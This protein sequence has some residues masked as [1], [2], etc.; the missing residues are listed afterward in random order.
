MVLR[1]AD[2]RVSFLLPGDIEKESEFDLADEIGSGLAS[3]V[4]KLAHHGS[5]TS[6]S[7]LFLDA[8]KPRLAVISLAAF[9]SYGFPHREVIDRLQRRGI[10]WL[11]TARSGGIMI[12]PSPEGL[13][14]EVS[15]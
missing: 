9:N 13:E 10:R 1:V 8:V 12:A 7:A 6:S 2:S 14:I 4:L 5:R 3:S 15:K 11:T